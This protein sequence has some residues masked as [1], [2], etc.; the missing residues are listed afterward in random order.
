MPRGKTAKSLALIE[1]CRRILQ[2]IHPAT[3]GAV[4]YRLFIAGVLESMA[5]TCT[6][7]VSDQLVYAREHGMV[8]WDWIVD[9]TRE[10][11]RVPAW[12]NPAV[13]VH[14]IRRAYRRDRWAE[15]PRRVEVWSEKGTVRGTLAP[16]LEA[17][18]L[19]FR[20]MHGYASATVLYDVARESR[21][22]PRPL[23]V[24]CAGDWDPS[25]LHMSEVDL[26]ARLSAYG[27]NM[28][29][30]RMALTEDDVTAGELPSFE[31]DTK[32]R[33]SRYHWFTDRYGTRCW[34]L[35]ALNLVDFRDRVEETVTDLIDWER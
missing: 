4:C 18:G 26:P 19:T 2:E 13:F 35:D 25:G 16:V 11:E 30:E 28:V 20:V 22:D 1:S 9:E 14:T 6:N 7:R 10:A 29:L 24:L 34:E 12:N 31:A 23:T 5:K 32:T 3:I 33:D 27:A 17:Y 21:R 8:P 15:Q